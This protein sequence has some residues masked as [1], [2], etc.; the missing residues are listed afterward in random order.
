MAALLCHT[1]SL[2]LFAIAQK[3]KKQPL[4][5]RNNGCLSNGIVSVFPGMDDF[6]PVRI[7]L[8]SYNE[9]ILITAFQE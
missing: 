9:Y 7:R 4:F 2:L 6:K 5:L 8:Y 1:S 3:A